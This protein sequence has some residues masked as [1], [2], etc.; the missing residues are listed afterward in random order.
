MRIGVISIAYCL[1][2]NL[3]KFSIRLD[4]STVRTSRH[5]PSRQLN[6]HS[7]AL[8]EATLCAH[9]LRWGSGE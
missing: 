2:A 9:L 6:L 1:E 8:E 7:D 5:H 3:Q 4:F